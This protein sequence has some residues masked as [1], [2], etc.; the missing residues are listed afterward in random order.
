MANETPEFTSVEKKDAYELRRYAPTIEAQVIVSGAY[1]STMGASFRLLAGYI[2]G[3]NRSADGG[4]QKIAMTA[5]V[6]AQQTART[7]ALETDDDKRS[8]LVTF[9]MPR[10]WTMESLP[11]PKDSRVVLVEN[12]GGLYVAR[13]FAGK[14]QKPA[15]WLAEESGLRR[16]L[17][18]AGLV[19]TGPTLTAQYNGPWVPGPMRKNE[20][21]IPVRCVTD[22]DERCKAA[23]AP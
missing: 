2:F 9:T 19:A 6:T 10:E 7:S 1:R 11:R 17:V 13:R 16:A 8:W 23:V 21:L 12:P 4:S 18:T 22:G 14:L 15:D 20:V 3:K 5:P